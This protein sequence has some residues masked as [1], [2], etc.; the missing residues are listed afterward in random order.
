MPSDPRRHR[1]TGPRTAEQTRR[2][3]PTDI[4]RRQTP[5]TATTSV[6]FDRRARAAG[7]LSHQGPRVRGNTTS[8]RAFD[9]RMRRFTTSAPRWSG[10]GPTDRRRE[11]RGRIGQQTRN[12]PADRGAPEHTGERAGVGRAVKASQHGYRQV[13]FQDRRPH[14]KTTTRKRVASVC[15]LLALDVGQGGGQLGALR[16]RGLPGQLPVLDH[17]GR[18]ADSDRVVG[19]HAADHGV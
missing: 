11:I 14:A 18:C 6:D 5:R 16:G 1:T 3:A 19:D 9:H 13:R 7:S 4:H 17:L 12:D 8:A 2:S 10:R 15:G